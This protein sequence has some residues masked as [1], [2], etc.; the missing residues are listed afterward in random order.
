MDSRVSQATRITFLGLIVNIFLV[1]FKIL[2]GFLGHSAAIIADAIHSFSD[3]STDLA[4][5]WGVK[6]ASQPADRCHH[7]GHGKIETMVSLSVSLVLFWVGGKILWDGGQ[8]IL[9]ALQ[10]QILARPGWI[11]VVA[12][13]LSIVFKEWIYRKT[14]TI[15]RAIKSD[16]VIANAWHHRSDA[17]SSAAVMLGILGAIL[18]GE[19]WHVLDPLAAVAVSFFIFKAG[20]EIFFKSS[21]ELVEAS[22]GPETEEEILA[23]IR[24]IPGAAEPHN[25]KTRRIGHEIAIEIHVRVHP[26]LNIIEAHRISSDIEKKIKDRFGAGT[27]ISV[28]VEPL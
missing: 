21:S 19:R 11:A 14:L 9:L 25:L 18:L 2:S 27:F 12:A 26:S 24:D 4:T 13:A 22:L 28:H 16:A 1:L 6:V 15:G 17:L 3:L 23:L 10:G 5:L 7:Y 8:N 20:A